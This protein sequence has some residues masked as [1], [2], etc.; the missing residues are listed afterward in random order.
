MVRESSQGTENLRQLGQK[1]C[2]WERC[3]MVLGDQPGPPADPE[4]YTTCVAVC[5][6]DTVLKPLQLDGGP[7][8]L[9]RVDSMWVLK[10]PSDLQKRSP[11]PSKSGN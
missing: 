4:A 3:R 9:T 2:Q 6:L 10:V 7:T 5:S 8:L 11:V 1:E